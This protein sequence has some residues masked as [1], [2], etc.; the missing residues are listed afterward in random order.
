MNE[1]RE[2]TKFSEFIKNIETRISK[3]A[4]L[5]IKTIIG[6]FEVDPEANIRITSR[7]N[8]EIISSK[9]NLIEG[10]I[11]TYISDNLI[12]E[13]FGWVRDFHA[14]KELKGHEIVNGNIKAVI[15]LFDLYKKTKKVKLDEENIDETEF[16]DDM[17]I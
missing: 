3:L 8:S 11:T 15:S 5:E 10:D 14:Q 4:T 7:D 13:E 17:D 2:S 12:R 1:A 16:E 9:I 6:E